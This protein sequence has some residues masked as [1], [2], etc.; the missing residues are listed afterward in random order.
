MAIAVVALALPLCLV[1]LVY[2]VD[3]TKSGNLSSLHRLVL[4]DLPALTSAALLKL[5]GPRIHSGV[6]DSVDYVLYRPNP[7]MQM[8][9]LHLVIGGYALFVMF[10][11]PLLPNVYLSYN[12]V[13]FTGGAALLALLTFIQA[14]TANPGIVTMRTMAEYQT[15]NFD[16]VMYKTANS[17]K[18]CRCNKPARSKHCSV[19]DM[20]VARFDH[21]WLNSCVGE[22]N[23]R[24]F[25]LFIL[26]NAGLCAYSAVVLLYTLLGEVVA[27]QL[28]ESKYINQAT[29]EPTDATVWIVTRYVIYLYPVVCM[30]F[31]MCVVMGV[32]LIAFSVFH[33]YLIVS[34]RT[35]NEFFKQRSMTA[36]AQAT[37]KSFYSQSV[38]RNV[39]EVLFP[40]CAAP[41]AMKQD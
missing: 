8:V 13:Y 37:A 26:V 1:G 18:T 12:H 16:E 6:V 35:T 41:K 39:A 3:P 21:P 2:C 11:Q 14:S 20:C 19:C 29:G 38:A 4:E 25:V 27:L 17:C 23:Y 10:A 40:R 32:A 5:C 36:N 24:Y 31:F 30:L 22:R 33:A 7:L 9:Y 34:N 28:F 15:Y